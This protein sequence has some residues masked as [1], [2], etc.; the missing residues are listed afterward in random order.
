MGFGDTQSVP[1]P[2]ST[3]KGRIRSY[4]ENEAQNDQYTTTHERSKYLQHG[5]TWKEV[6]RLGSSS[7]PARH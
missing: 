5:A 7:C 3:E 6:L 1:A 4:T 2:L